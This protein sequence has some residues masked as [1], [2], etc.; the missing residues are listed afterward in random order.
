MSI[1][2]TSNS[3]HEHWHVHSA[4][5][6]SVGMNSTIPDKQLAGVE[7]RLRK[8]DGVSPAKGRNLLIAMP[9]ERLR[10]R[11]NAVADGVLDNDLAVASSTSPAGDRS[12][13][14]RALEFV[15]CRLAT[16]DIQK[17]SDHLMVATE[18]FPPL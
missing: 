7:C 1:S 9:V 5:R 13:G 18:Y 8:R 10:S 14:G 15:A 17:I 2:S 12:D 16:T 4:S 3:S 11:Q 6:A